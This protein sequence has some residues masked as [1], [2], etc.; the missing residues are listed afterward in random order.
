MQDQWKCKKYL[1]ALKNQNKIICSME[2]KTGS[3]KEMCKIK[4]IHTKS[5]REYNMSSINRSSDD[6]SYPLSSDSEWVIRH[7]DGQKETNN[8]Y[9][10]VNSNL[11]GMYQVSDVMEHEKLIVPITSLY[12]KLGT[13]CQYWLLSLDNSRSIEQL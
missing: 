11:K 2:K 13:L 9:Y 5:N 10:V 7:P 1:K 3:L 4:K 6:Y 8:L 12:V